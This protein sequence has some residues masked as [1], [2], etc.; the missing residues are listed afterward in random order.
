MSVFKSIFSF[1]HRAGIHFPID[2]LPG[3]VKGLSSFLHFVAPAIKI[4]IFA[5]CLFFFLIAKADTTTQPTNDLV[6]F[7]K[8]AIDSPPEIEKFMAS[9]QLVERKSTSYYIGAKAGS[10]Y[11]LQILPNSNALA[12]L[13]GRQL[14]AGRSGTEAYQITENAVNRGSGS[15]VM[16]AGAGVFF[17][18]VQ[19]FLGMGIGNI[20]PGSVKWN[21]DTFTADDNLFGVSLRGRLEISN[22]LPFRLRINHTDGSPL[23]K[24]V[25]YAYPNPP[26]ALSGFPSKMMISGGNDGDLKPFGEIVFYSVQLASAPLRDDFFAAARFVDTNIVHTNEYVG[27]DVYVQKR[28]G[29]K[30]K[31]PVSLAKSG[32]YPNTPS[33][34]VIFLC[35][36]LIT[37]IP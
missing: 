31:L 27:A 7:F 29:E 14:V 3:D 4:S 1:R 2:R 12:T 26:T 6:G 35:I 19:Q 20:K 18:L 16:T 13:S 32:G 8:R 37:L 25:E 17:T 24:L 34:A 30:V 21:G 9:Q 5:A 28:N 10:N 23:T 36:A 11:F 15:N 22:G 33:R